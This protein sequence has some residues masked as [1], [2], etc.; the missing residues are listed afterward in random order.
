M[1]QR[2]HHTAISTPDLPR[3]VAFYGDLLG[4]EVVHRS[5]WP[6]GSR[7]ADRLMQLEDTAS[8]LV[9]LRKGDC[10]I[11]LFQ[12]SSPLPRAAD[13]KRPVCDHGITHLCF[14]VDDLQGEYRRLQ[15]AGMAFH[16]EPQIGEGAGYV[17]GR[18]PDGNVVELMEIRDAL[19][20]FH[21]AE[22]T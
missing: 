2:I 1:I 8:D 9:M 15:E 7:D 10:M 19:H 17:Y 18:D 6:R 16:C 4:F 5:G 20:P 22:A 12:F 14:L 11:E 13:P 3:L 21:V